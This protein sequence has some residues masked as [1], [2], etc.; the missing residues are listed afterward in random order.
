MLMRRELE[1]VAANCDGGRM[2][3]LRAAYQAHVAKMLELAGIDD[4][5]AKA[6]RI[7]A[8]ETAIAKVHATQ[9]QTN[10]VEAG[11]NAWTAADFPDF[12]SVHLGL[13]GAF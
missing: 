4:A 8:L 10:N 11:A 9:E 2:A 12:G 13:G 1:R 6:G 3:E 5:A 7:V